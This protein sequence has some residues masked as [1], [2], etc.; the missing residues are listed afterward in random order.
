MK[1]TRLLLWFSVLA[2]A[3]QSCVVPEPDR[4][5]GGDR[6]DDRSIYC[7]REHRLNVAD[8][9]VDP[10]PIGQG[11]RVRAWRV[12]LRSD[13][14]GECQTTLQIRERDGDLVGRARVY[15]LRPGMN[16]IDFDPVPNYRFQ[17]R[18]HCFDVLADIAGTDR[19]GAAGRRVFAPPISR[20]PR[21][22]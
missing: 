13:A 16:T 19:R 14:S 20:T 11:D 15:R 12:R 2:L 18:E 10:D 5:S 3:L 22:L 7:G 6:R 1:N 17:R 8:L 9:D 21:R 4:R